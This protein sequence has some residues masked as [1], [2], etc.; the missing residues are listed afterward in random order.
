MENEPFVRGIWEYVMGR[1]KTDSGGCFARKARRDTMS[2]WQEESPF[3]EI[4]E[5]VRGSAG[6]GCGLQMMRRGT[7]R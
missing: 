5:Q 1:S 3:R 6:V 7:L 4:L 2:V